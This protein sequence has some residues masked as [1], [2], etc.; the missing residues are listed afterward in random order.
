MAGDTNKYILHFLNN[1]IKHTMTPRSNINY[2]R[3]YVETKLIAR[4]SENRVNLFSTIIQ[5]A[6]KVHRFMTVFLLDTNFP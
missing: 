2:S 1:T 4:I 5:Y 6:R 3:T